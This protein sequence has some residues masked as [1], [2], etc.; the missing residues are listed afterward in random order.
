MQRSVSTQQVASTTNTASFSIHGRTE[1]Q[2]Q[3]QQP[4]SVH[5]S[6]SVNNCAVVNKRGFKPSDRF[7]PAKKE[8]LLGLSKQIWQ[9]VSS[10]LTI[11]HKAPHNI[12]VADPHHKLTQTEKRNTHTH[13]ACQAINIQIQ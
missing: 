9:R 4:L 11:S 13:R 3:Q 5:R 12:D 1:Q 10:F 7:D 8:F 2:Q 6:S